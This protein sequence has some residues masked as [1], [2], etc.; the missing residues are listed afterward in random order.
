M[1]KWS[2]HQKLN[3]FKSLGNLLR[4]KILHLTEDADRFGIRKNWLTIKCRSAG[5][6]TTPKARQTISQ[7]WGFLIEGAKTG[8]NFGPFEKNEDKNPKLKNITEN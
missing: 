7:R 6:D 2:N 3:R 5:L 1:L 4:F 8:F